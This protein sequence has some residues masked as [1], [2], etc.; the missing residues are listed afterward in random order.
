MSNLLHLNRNTVAFVNREIGAAALPP[1]LPE[2][3]AN[4]SL[5]YKE[6][7]KRDAE[8]VD[9]FIID[10]VSWNGGGYL[11]IMIANYTLP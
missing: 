8:A 7:C 5:T 6:K 1:M 10:F 11:G 9:P 2:C 3:K 4:T